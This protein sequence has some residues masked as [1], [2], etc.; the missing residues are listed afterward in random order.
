MCWMRTE[1]VEL[2]F[3][4]CSGGCKVAPWYCGNEFEGV[5]VPDMLAWPAGCYRREQKAEAR[6]S[7]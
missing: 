5:D 2:R 7:H 6:L 4:G 1:G 3:G